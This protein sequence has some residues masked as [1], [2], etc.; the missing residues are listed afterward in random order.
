MY[1]IKF[2]IVIPTYNREKLLKRCLD[3]VMAQSYKNWEAIVVDNYSEDNT[4]ELVCSYKNNQ[5]KYIKIHN[6]G[7]IAVSRNKALD[8]ATGDWVC[9]LDSDDAWMPNKLENLMPYIKDYDLIYHGYRRNGAE[10]GFFTP[11]NVYFYEIKESTVSYVLC[12]GFPINPSCSALSREI[13]GDSRF[14]EDR[15]LIALE[16]YDFFLQILSKNIRIKYLKKI[17]TLYDVN[18]ISLTTSNVEREKKI[19][20]RW[21]SHLDIKGKELYP[22]YSTLISANGE[23]AAGHYAAAVN[24]YKKVLASPDKGHRVYSIKRIILCLALFVSNKLKLK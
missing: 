4:E 12:H 3:S 14:C 15:E 2:S 17:L 22:Y 11:R 13:I 8:V 16:D 9:F 24:L 21:E 1:N 10:L 23:R 18:G 19:I 7:V 20:R 5:I 6:H